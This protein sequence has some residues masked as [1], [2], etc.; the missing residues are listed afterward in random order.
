MTIISLTITRIILS[1]PNIKHKSSSRPMFQIRQWKI[2]ALN[3]PHPPSFLFL[4]AAPFRVKKFFYKEGCPFV[5]DPGTEVL[6]VITPLCAGKGEQRPR[7]H[8]KQQVPDHLS[9]CSSTQAMERSTSSV[10]LKVKYLCQGC[11]LRQISTGKKSLSQPA[12]FK[13][14]PA[15]TKKMIT[16]H[17]STP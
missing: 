8:Q 4:C 10:H 15:K 9:M 1:S 16:Q 12:N 2:Y 14:Q 5:L 6:L 17:L 7:W 13:S 11:H 3:M